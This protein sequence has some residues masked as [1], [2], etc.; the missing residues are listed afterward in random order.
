MLDIEK[1]PNYIAP[2][3]RYVWHYKLNGYHP[4]TDEDK[5][6]LMTDT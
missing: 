2:L 4:A 3:K 1:E 6:P 5:L